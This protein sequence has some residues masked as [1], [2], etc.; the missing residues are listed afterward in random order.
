M[1]SKAEGPTALHADLVRALSFARRQADVDADDGPE[2][3]VAALASVWNGKRGFVAVI[4]RFLTRPRVERY[5][6][7]EA[8][9][10]ESAFAHATREGLAWAGSLGFEMDEPDYVGLSAEQQV[11]RLKNWNKLRKVRRS[12]SE[13]H[14]PL[15]APERPKAPPRAAEP[16]R[17]VEPNRSVLGKIALERRRGGGRWANPLERLL[18]YF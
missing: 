8:I 12:R 13:A 1:F 9:T 3:A 6:W 14:P 11:D 4:L 18:A 16:D 7:A 17:F 2:P 10:T 15:S 5:V